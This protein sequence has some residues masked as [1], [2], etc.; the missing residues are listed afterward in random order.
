MA[1]K[2]ASKSLPD[3]TPVADSSQGLQQIT[4]PPPNLQL[5]NTRIIGIAPL[6]I[7][8]FSQKAMEMMMAKQM[9]G[10][11]AKK[12]AKRAARDFDADFQG[13][14]HLSEDGWDGIYA[15]AFRNGMISACR[16]V[17][18]KMTLVK[19]SLFVEPD[20]FDIV[21]GVPLVR[22]QSPAPP[23]KR[24]MHTRN[25]TGVIDLRSRPAWDKWSCDL[26]ISYDADQFSATDVVNLLS[27]V[28]LQVGVGEG[29]PD[30]R[31]SAGMGFG[32]FRLAVAG[33]MN[34]P[35]P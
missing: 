12:G 23:V 20:G 15:A 5:L 4:V 3:G 27:R 26:R 18:F 17:G 22:I 2:P 25:A 29:R 21:D 24:V 35:C 14:R 1:R 10:S 7:C 6:M 32:M 34:D 30:S 9:A 19:L 28:G 33:D 8:R 11:V 13:A 16:L 31:S